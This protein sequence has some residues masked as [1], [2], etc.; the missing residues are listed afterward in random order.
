MMGIINNDDEFE[1]ELEK[2]KPNN[3]IDI[4]RGRGNVTEIPNG[5]RKVIA[6]EAINGSNG[7]EVAK[8]FGVS[9][10][11]VSAYKNGATSTASYNEP[12]NEL[13][14]HVKSVRNRISRR[15]SSVLIKSLNTITSESLGAIGPVKAAAIARDMS[16]IVRNMEYDEDDERTIQNN[17]VFY[18]PKLRTEDE[19]D[20]LDVDKDGLVIHRSNET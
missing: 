3:V 15:A 1:K 12:N 18:S 5:L 14:S 9:E 6:D 7:T 19:F 11:S 2:L 4:K 17:I 16:S 20:V 8:A 13:K 10:S